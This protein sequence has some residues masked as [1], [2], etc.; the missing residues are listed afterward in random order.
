MA[1][2]ATE[3]YTDITWEL[4]SAD[5]LQVGVDNPDNADAPRMQYCLYDNPDGFKAFTDYVAD[6]NAADITEQM[7]KNVLAYSSYSLQIVCDV[8][9]TGT[10]PIPSPNGAA[11]CLMDYSD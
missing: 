11:C 10:N 9:M 1:A 3:Y 8:T 7:T 2:V 5:E 6:A 4:G